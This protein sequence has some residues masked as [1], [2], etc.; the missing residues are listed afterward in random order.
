MICSQNHDQIGNR[1]RGD[2]LIEIAG[3]AAARLAAGA[4][5]LAPSVPLLFMGEEYGETAPFQY[6]VSHG[7]PGLVEAVRTGRASEFAAFSWQGEVPDPQSEDTF[8]RSTL[9]WDARNGAPMLELYRELLR[10]RRGL[11][12]DRESLSVSVS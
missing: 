5:L 3:P 7:D 11:P 9:D 10:L 2:R 4:V 12:L 1:A 8:R 6:F